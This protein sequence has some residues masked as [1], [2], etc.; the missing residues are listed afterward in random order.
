AKILQMAETPE[1]RKLGE[2]IKSAQAVWIDYIRRQRIPADIKEIEGKLKELEL[3]K[4]KD[5]GT[6]LNQGEIERHRIQSAI[7][8]LSGQVA[9]LTRELNSYDRARERARKKSTRLKSV[10]SILKSGKLSYPWLKKLEGEITED[11]KRITQR[12]DEIIFSL[13]L[14]HVIH[15][16]PWQNE[17]QPT[18]P[19]GQTKLNSLLIG[20]EELLVKLEGDSRKDELPA[21]YNKLS[22]PELDRFLGWIEQATANMKWAEFDKSASQIDKARNLLKIPSNLR[23]GS[24]TVRKIFHREISSWRN[25]LSHLIELLQEE[26]E[27]QT[28]L[29]TITDCTNQIA[30]ASDSNQE[31]LDPIARQRL[32][33][34]K[35]SLEVCLLPKEEVK[36]IKSLKGDFEEARQLAISALTLHRTGSIHFRIPPVE[37]AQAAIQSEITKRMNVKYPH[38]T[39]IET[40]TILEKFIEDKNV[41][42]PLAIGQGLTLKAFLNGVYERVDL[43]KALMRRDDAIAERTKRKEELEQAKKRSKALEAQIQIETLINRITKKRSEYERADKDLISSMQTLGLLANRDQLGDDQWKKLTTLKDFTRSTS[44]INSYPSRSF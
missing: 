33:Y 13:T 36:R 29:T 40:L 31:Q 19:T 43:G 7:G 32:D 4:D 12:K 17:Q 18:L 23:M 5:G 28:D 3:E 2:K 16:S 30:R 39:V 10:E 24:A 34:M 8:I 20:V 35:R 25:R 38:T 37:E 22:A 14:P 44:H 27:S 1:N 6:D 15:L 9:A 21:P 26:E 42:V 41:F 11:L